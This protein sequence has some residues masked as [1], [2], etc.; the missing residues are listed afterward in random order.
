MLSVS[1]VPPMTDSPATRPD[2]PPRPPRPAATVVVVRDSPEG[3]QVLLL[4]RVER[5]GDRSSG[6]FV[7]PGGTLDR[8]DRDLHAWCRGMDDAQASAR[9]QLE[10]GGLDY[11]VAAI[12]ECFE[13]AGLLFAADTS[14]SLVT[15]EHL[16]AAELDT[17]R[18]AIRRGETTLGALCERFGLRLAADRLA[19][20]SHWLTPPGLPKRFDTRFFAAE[21]PAG[22]TASFDRHETLEHRWVRPADALAPDFGFRLPNATRHTLASIVPFG[23]ARE[24]VEHARRQPR[25]ERIMPRVGT[26]SKGPRPVMP[27]EPAYAEIGRLDPDAT[28]DASYELAPGRAVRL[29]E[30]V[31]RV[32][33]PNG[34]VMTG[35]GTNTYFVGAP[36][37]HAWAVI[38]PGPDDASHVAA[39]LGAAPGPIRWIFATHTHKDH[40]PA[41]AALKE[42]TDAPLLGRVARHPEWQDAGFVPDRVLSH[43]D[44][45][46][47]GAG[48]TL[49]VVHTPGH[50]SNHLCYLLEEERTLFTGDHVMQGSTVVINPPDG[51]MAE[52]LDSL[53]ALLGE[54]LVWLAPGHGF[55][56][57]RPA[58]AIE[59]LI[60]HRLAR[61]AR[62]VDAL[63]ATGPIDVDGLLP[64]VYGDVSQRLWPVARRSLTAHLLKLAAEG[65]AQERDGAWWP[66]VEPASST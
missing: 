50:A 9:L 38:D 7:F 57:E 55:L 51:D 46:T 29:S 15:L 12:R 58:D 10:A 28:G 61:E 43:G 64:V 18:G 13:E 4:R 22:Q 23:H 40:S 8:A 17:L 36:G 56:I 21:A 19:Y 1:V 52:Y 35:P 45:V 3:M 41:A 48:T 33:A 60:R 59:R 26:G 24:C 16:D 39:I 54:D 62:V 31:W 65:R 66:V 30:R 63:R 47:L 11:Y 37:G 27:D 32:T 25:I 42:R 34:S 44:R 20:H 6:A 5:T 2:A 14:G 53:R 49:R